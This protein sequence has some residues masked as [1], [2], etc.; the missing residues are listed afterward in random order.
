MEGIGVYN[1]L[2][3]QGLHLRDTRVM[4]KRYCQLAICWLPYLLQVSY[5]DTFRTRWELPV[6]ILILARFLPTPFCFRSKRFPCLPCEA[7]ILGRR[8]RGRHTTGNLPLKLHGTQYAR[9]QWR[10]VGGKVMHVSRG[11]RY[12]AS[13]TELRLQLMI[14]FRGYS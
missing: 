10:L 7:Q 5:R 3:I 2:L 4:G 11:Y 6:I 1:K 12:C 9:P 8:Y 13:L 14:C